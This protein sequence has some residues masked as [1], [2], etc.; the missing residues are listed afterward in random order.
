MKRMLFLLFAGVGA[1]NA[2]PRAAPP[3]AD[4]S[5]PVNCIDL[6]TVSGRRVLPPN[7]VVFDTVGGI[8]YRNDLQGTCP[9]A[10]RADASAIIQTESQ[11]PRLCRDDRIRIYDP[12]EAKATGASSFP[13]CRLGS[14]TAIPTH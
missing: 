4:A 5:A 9:S 1:C 11:S 10:T 6:A 3:L 12:V 7:A 2:Q 8:T 13:V 14:F